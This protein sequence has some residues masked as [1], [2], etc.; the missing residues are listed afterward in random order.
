MAGREAALVAAQVSG[1]LCHDDSPEGEWLRR[2]QGKSTRAILRNRRKAPPGPAP[3]RDVQR[4]RSSPAIARSRLSPPRGGD[5]S[6]MCK[7]RRTREAGRGA[8]PTS[9]GL[10]PGPLAVLRSGDRRR[11]SASVGWLQ[12]DP[13]NAPAESPPIRRSRRDERH[14]SRLIRL[15][16]SLALLMP[17]VAAVR[18]TEGSP[19][20]D[21]PRRSPHTPSTPESLTAPGIIE[22]PV[23]RA[24]IRFRPPCETAFEPQ[25]HQNEPRFARVP[26]VFRAR[27]P[28]PERS[29][30]RSRS[31]P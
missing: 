20:S 23:P 22:S 26:R 25:I 28:R 21:R 1:S 4:G 9:S 7:R 27:S 29:A 10:R 3:G 19:P 2:Q 12:A 5:R 15:L 31:P 30:D 18:T 17:F 14:A 16:G 11:P 6:P 8:A 24:G 13:V